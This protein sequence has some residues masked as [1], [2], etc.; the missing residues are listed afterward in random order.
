MNKTHNRYSRTSLSVL[1]LPVFLA[2]MTECTAR[3][4]FAPRVS[5]GAFILT[6]LLYASVLFVIYV[7]SKKIW[8]TYT[9]MFVVSFLLSSASWSKYSIRGVALQPSDLRYTFTIFGV[10]GSDQILVSPQMILFVILSVA[11]VAL[12]VIFRKKLNCCPKRYYKP[13]ISATLIFLLFLPVCGKGSFSLSFVN[14]LF[15]E[16]RQR[17]SERFEPT[18]NVIIADTDTNVS[19][20]VNSKEYLLELLDK[21]DADYPNVQ[22]SE[23]DKPDVIVILSE[24]FWDF[25]SMPGIQLTDDPTPNYHELSKDSVSGNFISRTYAGGT[26]GVEF[27]VLTGVIYRYLSGSEFTYEDSV[28]TATPTLATVFKERGYETAA[29]HTYYST[30]Y[31]RD[32]AMSLMGFDEF[33][34][35]EQMTEVVVSGRYAG[36]EYLMGQVIDKLE[37]SEN[38]QFIFAITMEAHQPYDADRYE[39]NS[40]D[41][42]N[43]AMPEKL[44]KSAETYIQSI[45][46]ADAAL[47]TLTD[48]LS[49]RER[50]TVVL[51]F[52]DHQPNLGPDYGLYRYT[53]QLTDR[54]N[55]TY[56]EAEDILT[57][58]YLIWSNYKTESAK[59]SGFGC[60]YL[61]NMLLNYIGGDKPLWY[62]FQDWAYETQFRYDN[63]ELLFI[64]SEGK[65]YAERPAE[66]NSA[67]ATYRRL[68]RAWLSMD[69]EL[70]E[71]LA[72][73]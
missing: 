57:V 16:P 10:I 59:V 9:L 42:L 70:Y 34:G 40:I 63:R 39:E 22:E 28:K 25:S 58:P 29:I 44:R 52:G 37:G 53:G 6:A 8:L 55:I 61:G 48:Y 21:I 51:F 68:E 1:L 50:P 2:Y 4:T 72:R 67:A 47:K 73:E 62:R 5:F 33:I 15:D 7:I 46:N 14:A 60:N 23:P 35:L 31:G 30:F 20:A 65:E 45:R 49:E 13:C 71:K 11:V 43:G 32:K 27:E 56:S 26:A 24:S 3:G 41:I 69:G 54:E 18:D 64:D 36:D 66:Y 12:L 38:P 17:I 19:V